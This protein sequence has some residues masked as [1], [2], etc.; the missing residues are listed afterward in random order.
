MGEML[1]FKQLDHKV[2]NFTKRKMT[3][4]LSVPEH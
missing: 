4:V 3:L 2:L 1:D